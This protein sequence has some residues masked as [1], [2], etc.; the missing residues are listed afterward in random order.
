MAEAGGK[1]ESHLG[2]ALDLAI[3]IIRNKLDQS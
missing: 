3:E 2:E 1:D